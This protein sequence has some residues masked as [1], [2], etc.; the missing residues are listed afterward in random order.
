MVELD[1]PEAY[2][3]VTLKAIFNRKYIDSMPGPLDP[4]FIN[5]SLP[6]STPATYVGAPWYLAGV[7]LEGFLGI[8]APINTHLFSPIGVLW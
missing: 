7:I 8:F 4:F 5:V 6:E 1:A 3:A 2:E